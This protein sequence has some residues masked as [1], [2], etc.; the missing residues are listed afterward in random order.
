MPNILASYTHGSIILTISSQHLFISNP[1]M[2]CFIFCLI[3]FM[4][5]SMEKKKPLSALRKTNGPHLQKLKPSHIQK[6]SLGT[7][8]FEGPEHAAASLAAC[9][10]VEHYTPYWP[11]LCTT[12]KGEIRRG[13]CFLFLLCSPAQLHNWVPIDLV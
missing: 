11:Q 5:N 3:R 10:S 4:S 6:C 12:G 9:Y 2:Y 7:C 1:S 13:R 8:E